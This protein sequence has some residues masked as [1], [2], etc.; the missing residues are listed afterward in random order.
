MTALIDEI[1]A[2]LDRYS[3]RR[4]S[5]FVGS[6]P[7][8]KTFPEL[9]EEVLRLA[10]R[11]RSIGLTRG[12]RV[13]LL[14]PNSIWWV[15]F[16]LA[17]QQVGAISVA[18]PDKLPCPISELHARY[19]LNLLAVSGERYRAEVDGI[20]AVTLI[21]DAVNVPVALTLEH[22]T[23]A[24]GG[25]RLPL[26]ISFSS[27][28]SGK[29]KT[30]II[31]GEGTRQTVT[32]FC[33]IFEFFP[34][35]NFLIFL[36]LSSYQQRLMVHGCALF[37]INFSVI[38]ATQL[39]KGFLH[40][41]PTLLLA[42]PILFENIQDNFLRGVRQA[43]PMQRLAFGALNALAAAVP[44]AA[45][46]NRATR[47]AYAKLHE[48]FGG[49]IRILWTGMA[50]IRPGTL[51]FFARAGFTLYEAYGLNECGAIASNSAAAYRRGSVGRPIV[52]GS[53][54]LAEDGEVLVSIQDPLAIGYE[55]CEPGDREQIFRPDGLLGTGDLGY[56][57]ADGFLYLKG[58][59]KEIII[60]R[61]GFKISPE[62]LEK[63]INEHPAVLQSVVFGNDLETLA[64]VV[65]LEELDPAVQMEIEAHIQRMN[66][67]EAA[68]FAIQKTHF[69]TDRFSPEN[70]LLTRNLK[71]D[72]KAIFQAYRSWLEQAPALRSA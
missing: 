63:R 48:L 7:H 46:R 32:S 35:D 12:M 61:E 6:K 9:K 22:H 34:E 18:F 67:K 52:P 2:S 59:K 24:D 14:A 8:S 33:S 39:F 27:G 20:A 56:F 36:P 60:T 57:D 37:G 44:M 10:D 45:V 15:L 21:E 64:A 26:S 49:R 70:G 38:D 13:G 53:V 69:T 1:L 58:R 25:E 29:L 62:T 4:I 16:D 50:P 65:V 11:L 28:S 40:F 5:Y 19:R 23:P 41:R 47:T 43:K 17:I 66:E 71:L 51:A 3:D 30:L 54:I 68:C 72:R 42:P 55:D 31:T